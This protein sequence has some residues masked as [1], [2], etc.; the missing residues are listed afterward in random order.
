[1]KVSFDTG[2]CYGVKKCAEIAFKKGKM[3]KGEGLQ[4]LRERMK[5]LDPENCETYI[6]SSAASKVKSSTR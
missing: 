5:A 6:S 1:M 3:V 4:I 2:A